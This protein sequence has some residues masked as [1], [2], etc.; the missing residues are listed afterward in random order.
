MEELL[1]FQRQF[2]K[3]CQDQHII[4]REINLANLMAQMEQVFDIPEM[5]D[6]MWEVKHPNVMKLYRQI[7]GRRILRDCAT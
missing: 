1:V 2:K 3:I 4:R 7:S 6:P 5:Q